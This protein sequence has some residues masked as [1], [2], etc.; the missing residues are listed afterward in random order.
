MP[1]IKIRPALRQTMDKINFSEYGKYYNLFYN[2]KDYLQEAGYILK[3]I[4][5]FASTENS[6]L[7]DLGSGTGKHGR[8]FAD[9]GFSVVGVERS[10]DMV[11]EAEK[12]FNNSFKSIVGDIR[13]FKFDQ[14]FDVATA[15]FHVVSYLTTNPDLDDMFKS[16]ANHLNKNGLFIF[17]TWYSPA[18]FSM[19]PSI[20]VKTIKKDNVEIKRIAEPEEI[21][22]KN[23][24][25]VNYTIFVKNINTGI[26]RDFKELH[27]MRHFSTPEIYQFAEKH[28]FDLVHSEEFLTGNAPSDRT[29]GVVFVM[30]KK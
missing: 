9:H 24:V 21:P 27:P 17:D 2:E 7:L 29:W 30:R 13:S 25:N 23:I 6:S 19:R 10:P 18:V 14:K 8:L 28:D 11:G 15:L 22:H 20:R 5:N 3:L 26:S 4:R 1:A 12:L 16:V